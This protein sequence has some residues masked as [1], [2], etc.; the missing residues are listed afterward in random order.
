MLLARP[1]ARHHVL[2]FC[3][4]VMPSPSMLQSWMRPR[5]RAAVL[6]VQAE[7]RCVAATR[8]RAPSA[9]RL[10]SGAWPWRALRGRRRLR[11]LRSKPSRERHNTL[12]GRSLLALPCPMPVAPVELTS[13][14]RAAVGQAGVNRS[15]TSRRRLREAR[16]AGPPPAR[17]RPRRRGEDPLRALSG[18]LLGARRLLAGLRPTQASRRADGRRWRANFDAP[19]IFF[20][21]RARL[22]SASAHAS[23]TGAVHRTAP[24]HGTPAALEWHATR[25]CTVPGSLLLLLARLALL[26]LLAPLRPRRRRR[27]RPSS[28]CAPTGAAGSARLRR[29]PAAAR[30][31]AALPHSGTPRPREAGA[32]RGR[33]A[34]RVLGGRRVAHVDKRRGARVRGRV[35]VSWSPRGG[36]PARR[37]ASLCRNAP[38]C[39]ALLHRSPARASRASLASIA[40]LHRPLG[41]EGVLAGIQMRRAAWCTDLRRL[42]VFESPAPPPR[43]AAFH[44]G[45]RH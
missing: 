14:G 20:S 28:A 29:G 26:A 8:A 38:S 43:R 32:P 40:A 44:F 33:V 42:R 22:T 16:E 12:D 31:C 27:R 24:T 11:R 18:R 9:A 2:T 4:T 25:P 5:S 21:P 39:G 1:A 3:T 23:T 15:S 30:R 45:R 17:S 19:D 6:F 35:E 34:S 41:D 37:R 13:L 10:G 7:Q 36:V